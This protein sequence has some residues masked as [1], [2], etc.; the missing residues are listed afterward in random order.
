MYRVAS[1][2]IV[3]ALA[4]NPAAKLACDVWCQTESH[5]SGAADVACHDGHRGS[6]QAIQATTDNCSSVIALAPFLTKAA[7]RALP[8]AGGLPVAESTSMARP[9]LYHPGRTFL[10]LEGPDPPAGTAVTI[11]RV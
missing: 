7:Y 9:G 5:R 10:L 6:G 8:T 1:V 4:G 3:M 2:V 11:L